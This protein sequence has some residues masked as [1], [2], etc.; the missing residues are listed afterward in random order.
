MLK[1][2]LRG[3]TAAAPTRAALNVSRSAS[4]AAANV[5]DPSIL[6]ENSGELLKCKTD[7][8][9]K[10]WKKALDKMVLQPD[11]RSFF[12]DIEARADAIRGVT[13]NLEWQGHLQKASI[14]IGA[15]L[16]HF[17][18]PNRTCTTWNNVIGELQI[19]EKT[20]NDLI[21]CVLQML[22]HK[23]G[24][25]ASDDDLI[26]LAFRSS[27]LMEKIRN[28]LTLYLDTFLQPSSCSADNIARMTRGTPGRRAAGPCAV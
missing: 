12:L 24:T 11:L 23:T 5:F 16:Q 20:T 17:P 18:V 28:I 15:F 7:A 2:V 27:V 14:T 3:K 1:R 10:R 8:N 22:W 6:I 13:S 9:A 4:M 26:Q 21:Q 19:V 25:K